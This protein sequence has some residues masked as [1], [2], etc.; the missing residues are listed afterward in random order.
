MFDSKPFL[1]TPIHSPFDFS[2]SCQDPNNLEHTDWRGSLQLTDK[3]EGEEGSALTPSSRPY[4]KQNHHF[5]L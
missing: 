3:W 1:P 2:F 4:F 5:I